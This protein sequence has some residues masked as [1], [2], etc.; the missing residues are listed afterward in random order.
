M[1][2][3]CR[4]WCV[5]FSESYKSFESHMNKEETYV[6]T[7]QCSQH[8]YNNTCI[9]ITTVLPVL[10]TSHIFN[11]FIFIFQKS[12]SLPSREAKLRRVVRQ[13]KCDCPA[14]EF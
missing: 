6:T 14:G 13:T 8:L 2:R 10:L 3:L 12:K 7:V 5:F 1:I 11:I 9:V 4:H